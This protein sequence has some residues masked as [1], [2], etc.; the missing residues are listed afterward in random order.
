[1]LE[2][3]G[4]T[5]SM[6]RVAHCI[7]NGPM[8]GF[9]GIGKGTL[10]QM[11]CYSFALTG[12]QRNFLKALQFPHWAADCTALATHIKLD[13]L[14]AKTFSRVCD[15]DRYLYGICIRKFLL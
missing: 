4:M 15:R 14:L 7:D 5:Q 10:I 8:E 11:E 9:W 6:S 13:D 1:M 12:I 3:A 2:E